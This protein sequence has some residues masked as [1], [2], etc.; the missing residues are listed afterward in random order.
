MN[1]HKQCPLVLLVNVGRR[2]GK[3]SRNGEVKLMRSGL[4][5]YAAEERS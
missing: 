1:F 3:T 5:E 4:L 2:E